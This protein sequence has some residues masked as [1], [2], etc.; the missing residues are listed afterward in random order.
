M[1]LGLYIVERG[2]DDWEYDET[3]AVVIAAVSEK[4]ALRYASEPIA[5]GWC[6]H[7]DDPKCDKARTRYEGFKPDASNLTVRLIGTAA[8]GVEP[9]EVLERDIRG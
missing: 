2:E 1:V 7:G 3:V 6:V 8:P 5:H 4:A 9:G